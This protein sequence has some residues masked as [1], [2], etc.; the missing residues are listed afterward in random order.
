M[1]GLKVK[2]DMEAERLQ[3]D[4][5]AWFQSPLGQTMLANQRQTV[6]QSIGRFFGYHQLELLVSHELPVGQSSLL[7]HRIISVPRWEKE[8]PEGSLVC[9]SHEL[10]LESDSIDLVI[11]HHTLDVAARPHQSLREAARVLRSGGHMVIIGFNPL[12][13]WGLRRAIFR[14]PKAPWSGRFLTS[15]RLE[16]WLSL[17]DFRLKDVRHCFYAPPVTNLQ[18]LSRLAFLDKFGAR[19]RLPLGAYYT[20]VAQKRVGCVIPLRP[21]WRSSRV[22]G[23]AVVHQFTPYRPYKKNEDS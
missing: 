2:S 15:S 19:F 13:A 3:K 17:L 18:W 16:D 6:E 11:L 21:Q 7:G 5:E 9:H 4:F 8:L 14:S 1:R 22:A 12:S 10:P 20:I 23:A